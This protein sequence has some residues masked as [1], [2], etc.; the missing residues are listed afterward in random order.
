MSQP[1]ATESDL[2]APESDWRFPASPEPPLMSRLLNPDTDPVHPFP[3]GVLANGVYDRSML[4]KSPAMLL[5]F[6]AHGHSRSRMAIHEQ[7]SITGSLLNVRYRNQ[8][9]QLPSHAPLLREHILEC[10]ELLLHPISEA[11]QVLT[12]LGVSESSGGDAAA[13]GD[14]EQEESH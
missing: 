2:A 1:N 10:L 4:S 3:E 12:S 8:S 7:S 9:H 14:A 5:A 6:I 13:Q 11:E